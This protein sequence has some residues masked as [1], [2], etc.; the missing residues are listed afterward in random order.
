MHFSKFNCRYFNFNYTSDQLA[1]DD[2]TILKMPEVHR[3]DSLT[4][5]LMP[6]LLSPKTILQQ[7]M[8]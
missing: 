6:Y 8:S 5:L 3:A 4:A 1:A 7:E 2:L